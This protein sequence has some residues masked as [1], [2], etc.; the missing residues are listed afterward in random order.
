[1]YLCSAFLV[2][3][4]EPNSGSHDYAAA[5]FP[6]VSHLPSLQSSFCKKYWLGAYDGAGSLAL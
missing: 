6:T 5:V 4:A 1:M 3:A 2:G